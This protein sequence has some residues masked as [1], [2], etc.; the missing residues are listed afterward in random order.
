[1]GVN[2]WLSR[3]IHTSHVVSALSKQFSE[4][5]IHTCRMD[6]LGAT[7]AHNTKTEVSCEQTSILN[8]TT[9]VIDV[10]AVDVSRRESCFVISC[11]RPEV[12]SF[13]STFVK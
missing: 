13:D 1:M 3:L 4:Q 10:C 5:L 6:Y 12:V 2:S 8:V 9:K 11:S 7:F